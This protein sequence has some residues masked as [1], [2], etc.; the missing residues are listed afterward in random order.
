MAERTVGEV[1]RET[2][3]S[4]RSLHHYDQIGLVVPT[5]RSASG[6]R[7]YS[8]DD[9]QHL[10]QVCTYRALGFSLDEIAELLND[11]QQDAIAHLRHQ[12]QL[13]GERIRQLVTVQATIET[14]IEASTMDLNLTTEEIFEIF[15]GDDP[16]QY[17]AESRERWG[18]TD[19]FGDSS[20]RTRRYTA[21]DWTEIKSEAERIERDFAE[22]L[23]GG[24]P[25]DSLAACAVADRHRQHI[26]QW[27]YPCTY[28]MHRSLADLY[29]QDARFTE[30]Y[31]SR[32]AGLAAFVRDAIWANAT[33]NGMI[34][35]DT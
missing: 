4:V 18:E 8:D 7:L 29:V 25:A 30:H 22:L 16:R 24:T 31:E 27:F 15:G 23:T 34:S 26:T 32:K 20:R 13:L 3:L 17:Q 11:P 35:D 33:S 21:S 2:G 6:Y 1:A 12:H 14:M 19:A 5:A 28:E 10:H 9:V